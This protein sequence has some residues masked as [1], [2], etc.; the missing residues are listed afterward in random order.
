MTKREQK[1]CI[2]LASRH[3]CK[4][5]VAPGKN[6][7]GKEKWKPVAKFVVGC[8]LRNTNYTF[9]DAHTTTK[10]ELNSSETTCKKIER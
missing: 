3:I 6:A 1:E 8:L 4:R 10:Q 7:S 2:L 9:L 5:Y